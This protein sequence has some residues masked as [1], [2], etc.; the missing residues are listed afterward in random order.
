MRFY[1]LLRKLLGMDRVK[2][3]DTC[4]LCGCHHLTREEKERCRHLAYCQ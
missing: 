1:A 4:R 2:I 3:I